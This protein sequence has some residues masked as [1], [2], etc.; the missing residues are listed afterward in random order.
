LVSTVPYPPTATCSCVFFFPSSFPS[1]GDVAP[2]SDSGWQHP[3]LGQHESPST[4]SVH[5]IC[6]VMGNAALWTRQHTCD[7]ET[8]QLHVPSADARLRQPKA[9]MPMPSWH[10]SSGFCSSSTLHHILLCR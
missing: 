2:S 9:Q 4:P 8:Q 10:L 6:C 1:S 3:N 5:G 7:C